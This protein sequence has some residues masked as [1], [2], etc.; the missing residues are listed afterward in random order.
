M[1]MQGTTRARIMNTGTDPFGQ[2]AYETF[3]CKN[4]H[5]L[6][7]IT[8]NLPCQQGCTQNTK[9]CTLTIHAQQMNLL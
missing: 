5:K 9:I 3:A 6:T 4:H 7:I 2:W 8:A 1:T